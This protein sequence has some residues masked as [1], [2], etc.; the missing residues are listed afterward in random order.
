MSYSISIS[1]HGARAKDVERI[2]KNTV[3]EL[4]KAN[5]EGPGKD[6]RSLGG[7]ASGGDI[8][9]GQFSVVVDDVAD[10]D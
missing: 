3:R 4:R 6:N 1:G 2:V 8:D 9:G 5:E 7:T 10:E